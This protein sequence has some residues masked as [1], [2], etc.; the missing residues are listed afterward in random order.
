NFGQY[1]KNHPDKA[2]VYF[3]S[4]LAKQTL[5][6]YQA[7]ITDYTKVIELDPGDRDAYFNRAICERFI[8][9][10]HE[11]SEDFRKYRQFVRRENRRII[12]I[13]LISPLYW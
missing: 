2:D 9:K 5:K 4:A 3:N 10:T 1:I 12:F 7:A 6:K 13:G 11:A 8:G